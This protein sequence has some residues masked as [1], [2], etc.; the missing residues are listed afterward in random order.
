MSTLTS[1]CPALPDMGIDSNDCA[2]A[3][4]GTSSSTLVRSAGEIGDA[5][6]TKFNLSHSEEGGKYA[7]PSRAF[8][9]SPDAMRARPRRSSACTR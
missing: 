7:V 2:T 3:W 8:W 5:Q 6:G 9:M 1:F 4:S